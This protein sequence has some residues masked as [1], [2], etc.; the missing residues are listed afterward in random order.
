MSNLTKATTSA[1]SYKAHAS[2]VRNTIVENE[3]TI[4]AE[5]ARIAR[6][7]GGIEAMRA[8]NSTLRARANEFDASSTAAVLSGRAYK[9]AET[10]RRQNATASRRQ[11][12]A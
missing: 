9:A 5:M 7:Q 2:R 4:K 11:S 6:I 10:R 8:Q 3:Q 12:N 1:I